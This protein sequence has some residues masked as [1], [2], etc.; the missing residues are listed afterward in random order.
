MRNLLSKGSEGVQVKHW[1]FLNL[2]LLP[3]KKS[4]KTVSNVTIYLQYPRIRTHQSPQLPQQASVHRPI[5][6][7]TMASQADVIATVCPIRQ[8]SNKMKQRKKENLTTNPHALTHPQLVH[9]SL[10]KLIKN[11]RCRPEL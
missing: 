11:P 4:K 6:S 10:Y 3:V 2:L 7:C 8:N 1:S 9:N 5:A